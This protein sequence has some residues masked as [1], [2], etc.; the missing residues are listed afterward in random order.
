[1]WPMLT[2]LW[3]VLSGKP[4]RQAVPRRRR[5]CRRPH[6][7]FARLHLEQLETRLTPS[8][9]LSTVASFNG[10]TGAHPATGLVMD[11]NG[12]LYGTTTNGS[13][14]SAD[15]GVFELAHGSSTPTPLASFNGTNGNEPSASLVIDSS[16]NLY[17]TTFFGG[18]S[19]DGTLFEVAHGSGTLTTLASSFN[20]LSGPYEPLLMDSSGNLY[21]STQEFYLGGNYVAYGT[22]FELAHGSDTITTLATFNATDGAESNG[23]LVMDSNGNLYG[24]SGSTVFEEPSGS[25]T[26]NTLVSFNG[27]N[28]SGSTG[29]LIRD[30]NG[31]LYGVTASGGSSNDGTVFELSVTGVS[32]VPQTVPAATVGASYNQTLTAV[33]GTAP[34]TFAVTAGSL[35]AGLTLSSGGLLSGTATTAG[36]SA[37]TVTATDST[38]VSGSQA[39]T[40]TAY[41]ASFSVTGFPSPTTAGVAGTLTVEALDA[42]G[43]V[44]PSYQGTVHF[45]SSDRQAV[46]P[47]DYTFTAADQG[48]HTFTATLK[49]A[50]SQSITATDTTNGSVAGSDTGISINPAATAALVFTGGPA[51]GSVI[52]AG[53][54]FTETL[55]AE[56]AYGNTTPVYTGTVH[57]TSSDPQAVLPANYTFTSG[58]AGQ[59]TFSI[60]LKTAGTQSVTATDTVTSSFT[61]TANGIDVIAAAAAKFVLSAPS[62]VTHGVAFSVTLTVEDAYGNVATGYT[63]TVHFSSS[64]A[65]ATLPKSYTFTAADAG[66]HTFVN[67][68]ILRRK[69]KQTLTATD[70]L[71]SALTAIDTVNVS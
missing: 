25:G 39:Y 50:G 32:L 19:N 22:I 27:T 49:T 5:A 59:H 20:P 68:V 67:Q 30:S 31:N 12:N 28:G 9:V 61:A 37:F 42:N 62:S 34:Y 56:D 54:P 23:G 52:T 26:I 13:S 16:G 33:G 11:G 3:L 45:I 48:M 51:N 70:T 8:I 41:P 60:T 44:V 46:L 55:A 53:S 17:G 40:L 71:N 47:A 6:R 14:G 21:S 35:P 63:G 66:V 38:G 24:T 18:A 57:F 7:A 58:D 2:S 15:G 1:M 69:G 43:N 36:S 64:D 65:T 29:G 10:S 4:A